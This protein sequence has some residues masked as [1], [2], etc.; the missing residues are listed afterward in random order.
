M[1]RFFLYKSPSL[2]SLKT[3]TMYTNIILLKKQ[4]IA[5]LNIH[6]KKSKIHNN[7]LYMLIDDADR[8]G[9]SYDCLFHASN[10]YLKSLVHFSVK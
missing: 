3:G 2:T 5:P 10:Q 1:Q 4:T 6:Q 9:N 7:I 8:P